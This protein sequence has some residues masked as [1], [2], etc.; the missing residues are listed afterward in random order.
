MP[1]LAEPQ[2]AADS[3]LTTQPRHMRSWQRVPWP[4]LVFEFVIVFA[5]VFLSFIADDWR[6][7]LSDRRAERTLLLAIVRDLEADTLYFARGSIPVDSI[8]A[9]RGGWLQANWQRRDPP[10][11]SISWALVGLHRGMPYAPARSEYEAARGS[12]RLDLIRST[13]LRRA[14]DDH[15]DRRHRIMEAV[16]S[17]NFSSA[18]EWAAVIRPYVTFAPTFRDPFIGDPETYTQ[19]L[20]PP[21]SL[22]EPWTAFQLD[23]GVF[24]TLAQTNT[25]RR[26]MIAWQRKNLDEIQTLRR[27]ILDALAS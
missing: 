8:A 20:W 25:F 21:V 18:M 9:T 4:R 26:L 13:A 3:P 2:V 24:A 7:D 22:A 14:I 17:L 6:Q 27:A 19:D 11:D 5:A 12:G 16:S 23:R 15:F 1:I 10:P